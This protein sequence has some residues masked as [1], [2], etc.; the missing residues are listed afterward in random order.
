MWNYGQNFGG[1]T[2][3][4]WTSGADTVHG[5]GVG[6]FGTM[7]EF[8]MSAPCFFVSVRRNQEFLHDTCLLMTKCES[9]NVAP[10]SPVTT[11]CLVVTSTKRST[12]HS[13]LVLKEANV[14]FTLRIPHAAK[15]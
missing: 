7:G 9:F 8:S 13:W 3:A 10:V 1:P 4:S 2:K 5:G 12:F 6:M 14:T 15:P 11:T